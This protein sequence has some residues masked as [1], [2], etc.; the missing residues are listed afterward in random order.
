[1]ASVSDRCCQS[2]GVQQTELIQ[3]TNDNTQLSDTRQR[4]AWIERIDGTIDLASRLPLEGSV[5]LY[6]DVTS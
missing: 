5:E 6:D 4:R 2:R 1:M 3:V